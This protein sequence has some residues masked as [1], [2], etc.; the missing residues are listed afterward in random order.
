MKESYINKNF[1][2]ET[3]II[4]DQANE[5]I[6]EYQNQGMDLTLRQLYYQFVSRDIFENI[7][8]NYTK[9]STIISDARLAGLL[10]WEAIVDRTRSIKGL[11]HWNNPGEII[12][13]AYYS[14]RLDKWKNQKN[15]I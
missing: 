9:L 8:K 12:R 3:L 6:E 7:I 14:Y 15:Y 10:D 4:I 1:R 5:I 13:S 11:A 2:Q